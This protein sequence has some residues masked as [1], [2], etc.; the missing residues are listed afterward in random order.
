M[1]PNYVLCNT[2]VAISR[3]QSKSSSTLGDPVEGYRN[4]IRKIAPRSNLLGFAEEHRP[5]AESRSSFCY[6]IY[7]PSKIFQRIEAGPCSIY[8][9]ISPDHPVKLFFD[10][11]RPLPEF[12]CEAVENILMNAF[13]DI[14]TCTPPR[15]IL[16]SCSQSKLSYHVIYPTVLF[17]NM[18]HLKVFVNTTLS[19]LKGKFNHR[20]YTRYR[21]LRTF[22]STKFRQNRPLVHHSNSFSRDRNKIKNKDI[23]FLFLI[24]YPQI[25]FR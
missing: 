22:M 21:L 23:F 7:H 4:I 10:I 20:V 15:I 1:T 14:I 18:S 19:C 17:S 12:F 6:I 11:D 5:V 3:L 9:I 16:S 2:M 24:S 8:K 13:E 25:K